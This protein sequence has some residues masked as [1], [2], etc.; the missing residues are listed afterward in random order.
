VVSLLVN[1]NIPAGQPCP[2]ANTCHFKFERCPTEDNVKM[3]DFSCAAARLQDMIQQRDPS[4]DV[5][6]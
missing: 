4:S 3:V 6:Q 2:F 5:A 1:G